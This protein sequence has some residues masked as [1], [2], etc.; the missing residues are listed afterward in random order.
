MT[1]LMTAHRLGTGLAAAS[2]LAHAAP[3]LCGIS[4]SWRAALGVEDHLRDRRAVALTFDD[5]PDPQ[6]TSAVL[7]ALRRERAVA[8]FFLVGEQV[9]DHPGLAREIAAA[10][11][12]I[13]LHADRHRN[14]LRLTPGQVR[15]DLRRAHDT[16]GEA[17]GVACDTYRPP[18]GVLTG[19]ALALARKN[20]WG[21]ALWA[22][23]G[24][25]WRAAATPGSVAD[26]LAIGLRG[27]E[28]LL[29]HDADRY[30]APGCWRATAGALPAVA[31]RVRIAGL[32]FARLPPVTPR[33]P[34]GHGRP[35]PSGT[36]PTR[37]PPPPRPRRRSRA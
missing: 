2:V 6:G 36:R 17:T 19:A 5:G 1:E 30:G 12:G 27:G 34:A 24:R 23:W 8:T 3:A 33:G 21:V 29:L 7:E 35:D 13:A 4:A 14:L 22:R 18:Y 32:R 37:R 20:G 10:G 26:E 11:H 25:D 16:I 15:D 28:I 31:E 9:R